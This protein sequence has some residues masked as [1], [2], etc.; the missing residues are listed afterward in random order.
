MFD[1]TNLS[2][3]HFVIV[4]LAFVSIWFKFLGTWQSL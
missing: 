2:N 3:L 1:S 4:V